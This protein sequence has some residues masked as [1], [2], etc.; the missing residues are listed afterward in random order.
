MDPLP[1]R[2]QRSQPRS[3]DQLL[4][5]M[6]SRARFA[7]MLHVSRSYCVTAN[8]TNR[9]GS[10]RHHAKILPPGPTLRSTGHRGRTKASPPRS[11]TRVR[12]EKHADH[13]PSGAYPGYPSC[14][15]LGLILLANSPSGG[16]TV[17]AVIGDPHVDRLLS[18]ARRLQ[19]A[20]APRPPHTVNSMSRTRG[21][22]HHG[23]E[24]GQQRWLLAGEAS[25]LRL[26]AA[27][28]PG[29]TGCPNPA[30]VG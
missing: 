10:V 3:T 20:G 30:Q 28:R 19:L 1:S 29:D 12:S 17:M 5:L 9:P 23:E 22:H 2:G 15:M 25:P 18:S 26:M 24:M 8:L 13:V 27:W 16:G 6:Q 4:L 11:R 21:V 7:I 14:P